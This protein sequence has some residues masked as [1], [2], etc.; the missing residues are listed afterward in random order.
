MSND[1][2]KIIAKTFSISES[3]VNDES[4]PKTIESWDSFN[5]LVLVDELENHFNV[6]FTISEIIDVKNVADIK[7]HL[8]NHN[9]DLNG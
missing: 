5:G 4:G 8:K 2:Y 7:R 6:K 9:V 3:D 1:L